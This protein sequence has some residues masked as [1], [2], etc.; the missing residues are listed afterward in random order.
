MS[1]PE[2][3]KHVLTPAGVIEL[4]KQLMQCDGIRRFDDPGHR[5]SAAVASALGD[6]E[7]VFRKYLDELLPHVL[8]ASTCDALED[9]L[10]ELR[11]EFQEV[12]W[13]LWYPKSFRVQLLG[14]DSRPPSIDTGLRP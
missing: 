9:A 10:V 4:E 2:L 6:L 1:E 5:E 3:S 12:V 13:H 7:T 11:A 14:E 8:A